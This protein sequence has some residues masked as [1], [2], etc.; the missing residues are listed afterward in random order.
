MNVDAGDDNLWMLDDRTSDCEHLEDAGWQIFAVGAQVMLTTN[1]WT[2]TG[3]V[4]GACGV[5][6][7]IL[8]PNDARK[9]CIIMV[10]FPKYRGPP[11][12]PLTPNV[13]PITQIHD[14]RQKGLPLTL[15][16]AITIHKAQG[17]TMEQVTVDLGKSKFSSRLTFVALSRA[18]NFH[19]LRVVAF[20][21][22]HFRCVTRGMYVDAR[23]EEFEHLK[24]LAHMT[25]G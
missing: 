23:H 7:A 21:L 20:N 25:N 24:R 12:F 14:K 16:W 2:E 4:N 10:E 8:K 17:M 1:L 3:L 5:V 15:S 11:L 18:K 6:A 13:V 19:G 22:D 9:V